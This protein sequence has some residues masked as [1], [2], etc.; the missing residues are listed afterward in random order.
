MYNMLLEDL[1]NSSNCEVDSGSR[2]TPMFGTRTAC[3]II[4]Y[5]FYKD[6]PRNKKLLLSVEKLLLLIAKKQKA[7]AE[8]FSDFN[9][10]P[11][12]HTI[13]FKYQRK[14]NIV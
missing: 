6:E 8:Y 11:N 3:S 10:D 13:D 14:D 1:A 2:R 5:D 9:S 7:L 12:C 4:D